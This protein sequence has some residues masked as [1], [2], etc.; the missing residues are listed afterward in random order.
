MTA[1]DTTPD[2]VHT[3]ADAVWRI[4]APQKSVARTG[5]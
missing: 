1:W 5:V 2:D 3:F 4:A